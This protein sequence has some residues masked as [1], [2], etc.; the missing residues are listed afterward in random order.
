MLAIKIF[1]A[2]LI[3]ICAVFYV[4]YLWDFAL[5][6][7]IVIAAIPVVMFVTTLITKLLINVELAA[8]GST[9]SKHENFPVQLRIQNRSPFPIGKANAHIEYYNVFNN[10][11]NS[12]DLQM[13]IQPLNSQSASFQLN[14]RYCGMLN[15]TCAYITIYDPLRI[16]KFRVGKNKSTQIGILP[17]GQAIGGEVSYVDRI[18]EES[19]VFSEFKPGDDPSEVFD[20]RGYHPG[21]KLNRIHWKLSSKRSDFIVKDYSLP[22]DIPC[23]LFLNL[24]NYDSDISR[25][26]LAVFDTLIESLVSLS[27]FML[28]NERIH[29]I[30]YFNAKKDKFVERS[31]TDSDALALTIQ[32]LI[33]S[34]RDDLHCQPPELF[35]AEKGQLS[36]ASF[37][38]ISALPDS[39]VL[40]Y[41]DE[42]VDADIKNALITV[43]SNETAEKYRAGFAE[44]RVIPVV[45]GRVTSS[46][47]DIEL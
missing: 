43:N 46:V 7:L 2:V 38:F 27:Q 32:E 4:M 20:L 12:F 13:P 10:S 36:L 6:L 14:S 3:I 44:L 35:F 41:I 8:A 25:Y 42:N 30:V 29:T 31:I 5:V 24:K 9:A 17:E 40:E 19:E 28:E 1:F 18:T 22:V 47:K 37:T 26:T 45:L 16:F 39:Q 33:L 15:I 11:I 21:D 23:T 34:V